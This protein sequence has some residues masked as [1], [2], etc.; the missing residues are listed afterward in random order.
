MADDDKVN[1][2]AEFNLEKGSIGDNLFKAFQIHE[3]FIQRPVC[4]ARF[5]PEEP[6]LIQDGD[7]IEIVINPLDDDDG[8]EQSSET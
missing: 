1:I 8:S 4:I 6:I 2:V 7:T 5:K 3:R